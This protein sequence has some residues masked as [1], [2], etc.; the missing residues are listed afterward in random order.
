MAKLTVREFLDGKGGR[1]RVGVQ[2]TS[3]E[4]AAA[5]E[6]AGVDMISTAYVEAARAI[7]RAAAA[8][9]FQFGL[10]YGMYASA[11]EAL[12]AAFRAME[13]GA[14]SIYCP[15]SAA[16]IAELAREGVPVVGHVGLVPPIATWVGGLR[17]VGKSVRQAVQLHRQVKALEE[18]GA[19]GVE[20]ELVPDLVAA[21]I[22]KRTS[23]L[24]ISL[25]AGTGCD[26]QYLFSADILG[27]GR[28]PR[29]A[30]AY[31]RFDQEYARLQRERVAAYSEYIADVAAGAFPAKANLVNISDTQFEDFLKS[32]DLPAES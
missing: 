17:A 21:E 8:T 6:E 16:V 32:I 14:E 31:R 20:I 2:V 1:S 22:S 4:Q 23:I 24:T 25:G 28:V 10:K 29:H 19:F 3:A 30:K 13:D 7:P 15:M 9:H 12:R 26:V 5:A 11:T 18:A 27:E